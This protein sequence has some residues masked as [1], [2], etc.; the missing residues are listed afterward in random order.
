MLAVASGLV[1]VLAFPRFGFWPLAFV[2]VAG[3]SIAAHG[4]RSR[5]GAWLGLLYGMAFFGPLL[6]WTGIYVGAAPW[7]ILALSQAA[8]L[9]GLGAVLPLVQRLP[10]A[11]VWVATAWVLQEALRDRLPFGGFPW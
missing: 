1:G 7:L 4:R 11:P 10:A 6:H 8:F 5:T 3:F 2:S 9:A